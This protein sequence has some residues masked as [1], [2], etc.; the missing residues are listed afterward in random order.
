MRPVWK[1]RTL[2]VCLFDLDGT[3][4]APSIDF[5]AMHR[6]VVA[7]AADHGLAPETFEDM[8]VL[9]IIERACAMLARRNGGRADA[10]RA[11]AQ[12]AVGEIE[13][14]AAERV[15]PLRG[16]AEVLAWLS[17][18]GCRVGIVT[19]NARR[20]VER[21]LQR[22]PLRHDALLTRDDVPSV[23]PDPDH[24]RRALDVLGS[25]AESGTEAAMMV[26]DHP[27]D[28]LAGKRAGLATVA[29]QSSG[30]TKE[31]LRSQAP[32]LILRDV[33]QLRGVLER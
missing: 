16:A 23:K 18:G 7:V 13:M 22:I 29:V 2:E 17:D 20:P 28:V 3:L 6:R 24:L 9:E 31:A 27:M 32:D 30:S 4:I 21:I 15:Q 12:G 19:R 8:H 25:G 14:E 5:G 33:S 1:G 26:G 10:L 11:A